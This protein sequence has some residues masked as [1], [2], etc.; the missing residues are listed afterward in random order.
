MTLKTNLVQ[1]LELFDLY[2]NN[3]VGDKVNKETLVK[4][5]EVFEG[6]AEGDRAF[7]FGTFLQFLRDEGIQFDT[8]QFQQDVVI[9]EADGV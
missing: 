5:K 7:V 2:I 8:I 6:V 9:A 4:M 1:A 3:R